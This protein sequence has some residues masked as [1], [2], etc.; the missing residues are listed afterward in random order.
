[1]PCGLFTTDSV[2]LVWAQVLQLWEV[3]WA[4]CWKQRHSFE[5]LTQAAAAAAKDKADEAVISSSEGSPAAANSA[6]SSQHGSKADPAAAPLSSSVQPSANGTAAG[7]DSKGGGQVKGSHGSNMDSSLNTVQ[8]QPH[9]ELFICFVA[10]VVQSQRRTLLDHC[11]NADDVLRLFH[12]ARK[13]D[14]WQCLDKAHQL[15]KALHSV[16]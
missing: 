9:L 2:V 8:Q 10:A 14:L 6:D 7:G 11:Y 13:V 1:M 15:L 4:Y 16:N 3:L 12:S 5:Q